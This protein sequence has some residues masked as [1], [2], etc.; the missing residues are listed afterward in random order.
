[1]PATITAETAAMEFRILG[2]METVHR[3]ATH[4]ASG[5]KKCALLA[6]LVLE[7]RLSV[8]DPL[9][10]AVFDWEGEAAE[11]IFA[12]RSLSLAEINTLIA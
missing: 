8:Q 2:P 9:A 3:G 6:R 5:R 7:H 12:E 1:M 11:L 10:P 4:H